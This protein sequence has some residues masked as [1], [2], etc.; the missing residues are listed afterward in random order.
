MTTLALVLLFLSSARVLH[1]QSCPTGFALHTG[2]VSPNQ[3]VDWI[4]CPNDQ[5]PTLECGTLEVPL[6]YTDLETGILTLSLV[7][8]PANGA[9]S[10]G[11]TIIMNPGGPGESGIQ[12]LVESETS[13]LECVHC[14]VLTA[15]Y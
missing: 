13:Y 5:Q 8:Q 6:D 1:A 15:L 2:S 10:N 9:G 4:P 3:T 14:S 11:L 12:S 7:R